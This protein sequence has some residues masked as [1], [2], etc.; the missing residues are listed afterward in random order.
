MAITSYTCKKCGKQIPL[1]YPMCPFCKTP[2]PSA[3]EILGKTKPQEKQPTKKKKSV[4]LLISMILGILYAIYSIVYWAGAASGT[5][6]AEAIGAGIATALVM[7]HLI[8]AILAAIFNTLGWSM[9]SRGFSLTGAILY[10]VAAVLFPLYTMFVIIQMI[11]SFIGFARLK[12][13]NEE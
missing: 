9:N 1:Q 12:K 8:C 2:R 4:L 10:A 6:G 3:D 13:L 11:L 5:S 7:P